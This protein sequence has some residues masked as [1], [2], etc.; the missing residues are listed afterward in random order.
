MVKKS[1]AATIDTILNAVSKIL[2]KN[3]KI[4]NIGLRHGEKYHETL[5]TKEELSKAVEYKNYYKITS[6]N[7]DLNYENFSQK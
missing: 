2:S 4:K 6:D 1:P 3:V 5:L 7:R